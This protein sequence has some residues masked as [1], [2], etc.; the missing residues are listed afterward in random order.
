MK[1]K[2]ENKILILVGL[3]CIIASFIIFALDIYK[4]N[5]KEVQ[6]VKMVETFFEEEKENVEDTTQV[7]KN[8]EENKTSSSPSYNYIAVL[9]IPS[10]N[11]KRG[12]VDYNSKYNNVRYNIQII[13]HSQMPDVENSNLILAGHN[14]TSGVSFFRNLYKLKEDSLIYLY[15]DG[16][17]Y[18]YKLNNSYD[19]DK[20]G[21]IEIV[22]NRYKNAITLITC[23]KGTKDKQTVFIGYLVDKVEF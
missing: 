17:K 22:R 1:R 23:K 9:E 13:E 6:E 4:M 5:K 16:Y 14:G 18:I 7:V 2:K 11:L 12:I 15:Y 19:T 3:I 10:I 21:K 8:E 20:D